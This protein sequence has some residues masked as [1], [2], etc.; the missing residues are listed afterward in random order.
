MIEPPALRATYP[1]VEGCC[2]LS[3]F[4]LDRL[5]APGLASR[6]VPRPVT[7]M[8]TRLDRVDGRTAAE[9]PVLPVGYWRALV[10]VG[11]WW[12]PGLVGCPRCLATR[13]ATT[14]LGPDQNRDSM[15]SP[16]N[17]P[18]MTDAYGPAA[19][20]V[21]AEL[22]RTELDRSPP[23]DQATLDRAEDV[24]V[25]DTN[26]LEVDRQFL[27]PDSLCSVCGP[28]RRDTLPSFT[29]GDTPISK[30]GPSTMR[31]RA[32]DHGELGHSY[33]SSRIGLFTEI[34]H[35]LQSPFGACSVRLPS[36]GGA[37]EPAIGR[38]GTF[39]DSRSIALLE[40]LERYAGMLC[41][42]RRRV[43]RASYSEVA[44]QAVYPPD[45]GLHPD[46]SYRSEN[47]RYR[48]FSADLA[49]DWV[50]AYSFATGGPKLVP[51]RAAFWG[52]RADG[53]PSFF[54][55]TSNGCALGSCTEEAVLHGLRELA[56]R[57]SFLMTWYRR[58]ALPE[59]DLRDVSD[60][61]LRG[62]LRRCE[63]FTGHRFRAFVSTMEYGIPSLWL[64]ALGQDPDGPAVLAGAAAHPDPRQA[65]L[66]GLHELVGLILSIR[67]SYP[68]RRADVLPMLDDPSRLRRMEDHAMLACLP[69]AQDR[70]AFLLN[71]DT[72]PI[73]LAEVAGTVRDDE[74]D[75]RQDLTRAVESILTSG[76]DVLV[77]DQTMPELRRTGMVCVKVLVPGLVPV[78]F[79][80]LNRRTEHLPRLTE[81]FSPPYSGLGPDPAWIDQ[82]PHPFP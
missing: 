55:D 30:L 6:P 64:T 37:R 82:V 53:G 45:L 44:D 74:R 23:P 46:A 42:G 57:D 15:V 34:W 31:T 21:V 59:V 39:R 77:V 41:G 27:L 2:S 5:T 28:A 66:G 61:E 62:L 81:S 40:G 13:T 16:A 36:R 72:D 12:W 68:E 11:P 71:R 70:F 32:V 49:V 75:I 24:Y 60:P 48:A 33:V 9:A 79:G 47:F 17:E 4:L 76:M 25:V 58:L 35:D 52:P 43:V 56:E 7:I 26:T 80:H 54:F 73:P 10:F 67:H 1:T 20:N 3:R 14:A 22:V 38:A 29:P 51:E 69:E 63:L 65:L 8:V 78:T 19:M 50:Q 18:E